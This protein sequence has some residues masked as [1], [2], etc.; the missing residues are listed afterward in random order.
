M[1]EDAQAPLALMSIMSKPSED[2][3]EA[4][5]W[6]REW[7]LMESEFRPSEADSDLSLRLNQE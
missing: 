4:P 7:E 3:N 1:A 6:W 2:M 5:P